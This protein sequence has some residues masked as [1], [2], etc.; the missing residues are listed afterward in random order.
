MRLKLPTLLLAACAI[1][2][3]AQTA[4]PPPTLTPDQAIQLFAEAGFALIDGTPRNRCGK[5]ANP[6][7][8]FI[9]LNADR[10]AEAHIADVDP[11]CYGTP[12]AYF[13]IM[14][15][16][17][18]GSWKRVI[19]EDGI[20][21]FDRARTQ[22]WN[23]LSL[24]TRDSA[25]PGVRRFNGAEY[26]PTACGQAVTAALASTAA[27]PTA[28]SATD[29]APAAQA[30]TAALTG[31]RPRQIAQVL[32]NIVGATRTRDWNT[33]L[34]AFAGARWQARTTH[35]RDWFGSTATQSGRIEIGGATYGVNVSG[36]G[37]R[38]NFILFDSPGDDL[39]EWA[40]ID[41]AIRAIGMQARNIGCHSP[42]GFGWVR[43]TAD[44]H[45]A[46]LH[47]YLNYGSMVPATDVYVFALDAPFDGR[48]EAD[49]A[50]DRSMC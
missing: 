45:S 8:A 17:A 14:S 24:E 23:N 25:C 21:G 6:R 31:T 7:V 9:D 10:K 4:A 26:A 15:Q 20:V 13:A 1:P 47:K 48:S 36:T 49:V 50:S 44:G 22:G 27:S 33:V 46:V 42:T 11:A 41:T 38:V 40:Q 37:S 2:A 19:A 5:P 28:D 32:R 43:L 34:A 3:Y 16:Q 39:V 12:G 18:D 35:D 30:Q 29:S